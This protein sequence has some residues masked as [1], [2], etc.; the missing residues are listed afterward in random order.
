MTPIDK[1]R[2][3][4]CVPLIVAILLCFLVMGNNYRKAFSIVRS[5]E[6]RGPSSFERLKLK[7]RDLLYRTTSPKDKRQR[8][9]EP[10]THQSDLRRVQPPR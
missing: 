8:Q 6:V 1:Y 7:R 4:S 3:H 9:I 5:A 2:L 10:S